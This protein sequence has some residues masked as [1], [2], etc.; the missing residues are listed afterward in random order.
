MTQSLDATVVRWP[1]KDQTAHAARLAHSEGTVDVKVRLEG[2]LALVRAV[3]ASE[4]LASVPE[5]DLERMHYQS[6]I[7]LLRLAERELIGLCENLA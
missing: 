2:V 3:E 4:T 1:N 7:N 5:C 6:V